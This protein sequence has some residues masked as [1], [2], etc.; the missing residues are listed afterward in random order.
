MSDPTP[1]EPM[2]LDRAVDPIV[3]DGVHH[4]FGTGESTKQVLTDNCLTVRRGEI[5][6]M[7]GPS[8]SG[9]TTLLTLIGTLRRV[10]AGRLDV[11][12]TPL[13]PGF[14]PAHIGPLRQRLG[15]IFQAH[16]LFGSL[17]ALQNV[18]MAL[19]LQPD[20]QT[21]RQ[22]NHRCAALL[23]AVGLGE[24]IDYKP[25]GLSGGQRQRV[26]VARGLVHQPDIVLADEP[27]AALDAASGRQVVELFK[28]EAET[29]GA[30]IIIVTHD[31]R[32]ID[33]ADRIVRMEDGLIA[34][35]TNLKKA[36]RLAVQLQNCPAFADVSIDTLAKFTR[37]MQQISHP[38]GEQIVRQ[39]E[40]GD[41]FYLIEAGRV[42]VRRTEGDSAPRE[43]ATLGPGQYFGEAALLTGEPRNATVLATETVLTQSLTA[44]AFAQI[45]TASRDLDGQLRAGAMTS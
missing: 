13:G 10:Q 36:K 44:E 34:A 8:G 40:P 24:R 1:A 5:V 37:S 32:V 29:R 23:Q 4:S 39:G 31:Q 12:G 18:R 30:A 22:M 9:K 21:R 19:E 6:I 35:D 43:L 27:T 41:R 2:A 7:T 20:G 28:R 26:A 42:S 11:L 38:P 17:T 16:N 25:A 3:V 14:N 45:L 33:F 15:F